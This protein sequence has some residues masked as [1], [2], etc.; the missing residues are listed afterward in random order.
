VQAASK[1]IQTDIKMLTAVYSIH[2]HIKCSMSEFKHNELM[3]KPN[4][5]EFPQISIPS[6]GQSDN[7]F[8]SYKIWH[9]NLN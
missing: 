4:N 3:L 5:Y 2:T 6:Q 9:Y 8:V 7:L 1:I